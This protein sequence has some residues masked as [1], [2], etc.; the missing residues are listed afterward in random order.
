MDIKQLSLP[1]PTPAP[2]PPPP[3]GIASTIDVRQSLR[4]HSLAAT[5]VTLLTLG[6]G[7][8]LLIQHRAAYSAT[9]VI[10]VS[11]TYLATLPSDREHEYPYESYI[12]E[13]IHTVT[14]YDVLAG[15]LHD[16]KPGVFRHPGDSEEETV[17]RL[18]K[19][20]QVKRNGLS[21]QMLISMQGYR[22]DNLAEIVN[23]VTNSYLRK[24][25]DEEFY[26]QDERLKALRQAET[27][28]QNELNAA[29][30]EQSQL[31][32]ELG[33]AVIGGVDSDQYDEELGKLRGDLTV[34]QEQR[35]QAEA[36][37]S[38]LESGGSNA[39][40]SALN[41]A[42]DE[43]IANDP[44]LAAL[45]TSLSQKR[46]V[47]LD[48]LAGLTP[49]HPLRKETEAQLAQ[50][51]NALKQLQDNLRAKAA[52]HLEQKLR[53]D[54]N[55][56]KTVEAKL[57]GDIQAHTTQATTA[58]P[59]FQRAEEL[60][61]QIAALQQRYAT[62]DERTR[63]LELDSS[64]PGSVHVFSMARTPTVPEPSK[65]SR[66]AP[67]LLPFALLMGV[68]SAVLIDLVDPR[69][70]SPRDVEAVLGFSPM[71]MIFD[72]QE[73]TLQAFDECSLR[74]AAGIDQAA[75][76]V[77]VRTVV[78][79]AVNAGAGTSSIVENLGSTLAKLG[80]KTLTIDASGVT[81]PVAYVTIGMNRASSKS[82]P[83][84]EIPKP[85]ISESDRQ[86][87]AVVAQPI[88]PK[89][90][91]LTSFM[92]QAFKDLTSEYDLVLID[93]TPLLISA[94]TEYLARFADVTVLISES[95][96]TKKATLR[97]ATRLLERLN[98]RGVA[99]IVN[100]VSLE[101]ASEATRE[102]LKEFEAH[103][104]RMNL[105]WRPGTQPKTTVPAD[106]F[107]T[108]EQPVARENTY[109]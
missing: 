103:V 68:G 40:N 4:I 81:V 79:T 53:T 97:R 44:S 3:R 105:K 41:A 45:K 85:D 96:R 49:N 77:G 6:L 33:V 9:S 67:L 39:P 2:P 95:G 56:A 24:V 43:L 62:L 109:A 10:Y 60:K 50:I 75:R 65:F 64:S 36:E 34:A 74:L 38:S 70:Y 101:R 18:G 32:K 86:S 104:N 26:G 87:T 17:D 90:T 7:L 23:A 11:P 98:V 42:A 106:G 21:Y 30:K 54:L 78:L 66:F 83:G 94:E 47:L 69:V 22:P 19:E 31:G 46:A 20:L 12:E 8:A 28:V 37:L 71:G 73:V 52:A 57:N 55:R 63:N 72:D 29:L 48:Q 100:K 89:L 99:T 1:E 5:L 14:R 15:A 91:P 107:E 16:L 76:N 27:D 59:K 80:R 102:D 84:P 88:T 82:E 25:H 13:Q 61:V 108:S 92:D 58:G 93:A 35:I 51:E